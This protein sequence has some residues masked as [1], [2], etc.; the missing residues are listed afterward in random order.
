MICLLLTLIMLILRW[1]GVIN[2]SLWFI[3]APLIAEGIMATWL[4]IKTEFEYLSG[5][6][7]QKEPD[8]EE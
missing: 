6:Y 2:W 5:L 1:C 3:Y 7:M 4:F 8:E